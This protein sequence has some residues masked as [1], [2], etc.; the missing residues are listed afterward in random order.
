MTIKISGC[1]NGCGHHLVGEIGLRGVARN[2]GGRLAPHYMLHLGGGAREDGTALFGTPIGRVAVRRVP[3]AVERLLA[4][5][6]EEGKEGEHAGDTFA[7]LGKD[8]CA[9]RLKDLLEESPERYRE[10]DFFDLG[11]SSPEVFPAVS[12]G[13]K[14][15]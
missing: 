11:V 1:P 6:E 13:P 12:A 14:A 2:V 15:P 10:E 9:A 5:L 4:L 3:E 8:R 7:R